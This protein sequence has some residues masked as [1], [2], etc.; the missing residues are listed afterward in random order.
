MINL[1]TFAYYNCNIT[2]LNIIVTHY[3]EQYWNIFEWY[4]L[5][6][7]PATLAT[8]ARLFKSKKTPENFEISFIWLLCMM[9]GQT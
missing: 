5:A 2:L 1:Q 4:Y 6:T 9:T 3:D 7:S 8:K